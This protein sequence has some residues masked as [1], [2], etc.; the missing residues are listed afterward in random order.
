MKPFS[1]WLSDLTEEMRDR[2]QEPAPE[3]QKTSAMDYN[4]IHN[5]LISAI[6]SVMWREQNQLPMEGRIH[7]KISKVMALY[8]KIRDALS[9]EVTAGLRN[10]KELDEYDLKVG[11]WVRELEIVAS[12]TPA[13]DV[14]K[15]NPADHYQAWTINGI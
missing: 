15:V 8:S 10:Q 6:K 2:E 5:P 11:Q 13:G 12:K 3:A 7:A 9:R 14:P 4:A 1:Q